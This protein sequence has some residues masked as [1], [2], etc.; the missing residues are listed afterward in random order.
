MTTAQ[1]L[2]PLKGKGDLHTAQIARLWGL[3]HRAASRW[4]KVLVNEGYVTVR[5]NGLRI[6]RLKETA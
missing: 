1:L 4:L 5:G 3:E 6:Y 2:K